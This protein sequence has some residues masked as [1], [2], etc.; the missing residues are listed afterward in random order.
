MDF[1]QEKDFY[2]VATQ[3][4]VEAIVSDEENNDDIMNTAELTAIEE[5][6]GYLRNRY[7]VA[8]IF[9]G[10]ERNPLIVMRTADIMLYHLCAKLPGRMNYEV[11]LERYEAAIKWLQDIQKGNVV[12]SLPLIDE[13]DPG[14]PVKW[15]SLPKQNSTW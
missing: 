7:K 14:N 10:T 1:L 9:S 11:R 12:L 3:E 8:D 2:I 4:D 13:T 15:N 6:S 5:I